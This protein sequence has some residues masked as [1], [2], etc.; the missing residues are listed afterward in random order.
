MSGYWRCPDLDRH[1]GNRDWRDIERLA[2][3]DIKHG[4]LIEL[5]AGDIEEEDEGEEDEEFFHDPGFMAKIINK[6]Q[7]SSDCGLET[8]FVQALSKLCPSSL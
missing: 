6:A 4:I 3:V 1:V 7:V 5:V 8:V 2:V